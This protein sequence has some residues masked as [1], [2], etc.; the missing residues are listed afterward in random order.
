G[1]CEEEEKAPLVEKLVELIRDFGGRMTTGFV[2]TPLILRVL[3]DNG[4]ADVAFDLLLQEKNP[5][6]LFSVTHGATTI[7]EHWDSQKEDGSFWSTRMNSFNHYAYGSVYDWMFGDMVGLAVC[8]DG[9]GYETITYRPH[10]DKRIGF[11][12]ASLET[13]KGSLSASWKYLEDG[14]VRYEL[15]LPEATTAHV[16]IP[17]LPPRT[18]TGG[19]YV[20]Y[21]KA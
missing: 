15:N 4:R 19:S 3:S 7:W 2:G 8:D 1:L 11:A 21:S 6:W 5:S 16:S 13:R 14:T 17:G 12:R 9:A 10:T 18:V 20:F